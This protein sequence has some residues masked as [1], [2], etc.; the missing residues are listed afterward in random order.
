MTRW[1]VDNL[2]THA[3]AAALIVEN[4]EMDTKELR[5]DLAIDTKE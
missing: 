4:Y 2:M 1:H 3:L 5:D